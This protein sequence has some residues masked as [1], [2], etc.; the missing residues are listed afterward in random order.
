MEKKPKGLIFDIDG[1]IWRNK[2]P[3]GDTT[4][5]F[6]KLVFSNIRYAFATNN[7]T[8][9]REEYH[10]A[11]TA[12][13]IPLTID[14]LFTSATVTAQYLAAN[15]DPGAEIYVVG[16]PGLEETIRQRGFRIGTGSPAAVV[17]G[18]DSNFNY[19]KLSIANRWIRNGAIFIGTNPDASLPSQHEILPGAGSILAAVA[20]A[21]GTD[22]LII[23]KPQPEIFRQALA[24][25]AL[26]A[27][28]A[29]VIGDRLDTDI[30]GG[31]GAGCPVALV[32]SGVSDRAS[33][34]AWQPGIDY[35]AAD[36]SALVETIYG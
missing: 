29:L 6:E 24:H 25:L 5:I 11:L 26:T 34:E 3:I 28:E 31:Q 35:I 17:V 12:I 36:L 18:L 33:A 2:V 10:L 15:F 14:Q 30:A 23:G 19:E 21:S 22:P 1:V 32:L 16:M 9:S 20:T 7:S 27:E 8:K 4:R 13:G